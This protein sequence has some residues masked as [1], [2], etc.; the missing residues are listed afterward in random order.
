MI[1]CAG[2]WGPFIL[3]ARILHISELPMRRPSL[4]MLMNK[5]IR[6]PCSSGIYRCR[7]A[8]TKST[9]RYRARASREVGI[10]MFVHHA[11]TVA[12]SLP[13]CNTSPEAT[14]SCIL[15]LPQTP[16][17]YRLSLCEEAAQNASLGPPLARTHLSLAQRAWQLGLKPITCVSPYN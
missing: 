2:L 12:Q 4:S 9:R 11:H 16:K 8:R 10:C 1:E 15:P 3:R 7:H 13:V 17:P 5:G 14:A 6:R